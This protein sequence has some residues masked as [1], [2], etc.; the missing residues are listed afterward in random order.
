MPT[1][2]ASQG[3]A[4]VTRSASHRSHVPAPLRMTRNLERNSPSGYN[5]SRLAEAI[6]KSGEPAIQECDHG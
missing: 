2:D 5:N 4:G 1:S 6:A 3:F